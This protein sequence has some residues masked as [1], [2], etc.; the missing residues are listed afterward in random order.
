MPSN[1]RTY[2]FTCHGALSDFLDPERVGKSFSVARC[3]DS[4]VKDSLESFGIPHP[5]IALITMDGC[6]VSFS[7]CLNDCEV[8]EAYPAH[9]HPNVAPQ[10]ILP[11]K[12]EGKPRFLL[13][14]HLGVLA[15]HLRLLGIDTQFQSK[16]PGDAALA[17]KAGREGLILLTRD[18]GLLKR[19]AVRYGR[20]VRARH[21]E[22]QVREIVDH[23]ELLPH[24]RP[25]TRCSLCNSLLSE[26]DK[27]EV[28]EIVPEQVFQRHETFCRCAGCDQVYWKGTH[29]DRLS[30][31][32]EGLKQSAKKA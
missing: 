31:I 29:F 32:I 24:I 16:D 9:D 23:Y 14:V 5:E 26:I 13:D 10:D 1:Y 3:R 4:T 11:F 2:R 19:S 20:Y 8:V 18:I 27:N 21:G 22:E 7:T 25:F 30:E 12:P 6:P 28:R 15:K 17:R